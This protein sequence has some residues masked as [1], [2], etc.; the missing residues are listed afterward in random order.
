MEKIRIGFSR[1]YNAGACSIEVGDE[2]SMQLQF[3][4]FD[5]FVHAGTGLK[6]PVF[7]LKLGPPVPKDEQ[8]PKKVTRAKGQQIPAE[9]D[10]PAD[11]YVEIIV[12]EWIEVDDA[13]AAAFRAADPSAQAD[14]LKILN[15]KKE[16]YS[17]AVDFAAGLIGLRL[18]KL[19]VNRPIHEQYYLYRD[20]RSL[21]FSLDINFNITGTF[22]FDQVGNWRASLQ[23]TPTSLSTKWK[24]A[25]RP[26][27]WLLRAWGAEDKVHRCFSLLTALGKHSICGIFVVDNGC[28]SFAY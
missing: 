5:I 25:A 21:T 20:D 6:H 2:V 11:F 19:L 7:T 8:S 27:A 9:A 26:L 23:K 28:H 12:N 4:K 10:F 3:D 24:D 13:L 18:H 22:S 16:D 1:I 14:L 17:T 15:Q